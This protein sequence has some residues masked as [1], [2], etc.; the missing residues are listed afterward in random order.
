MGRDKAWLPWRGQPMVA[1]VVGVLRAVVDEVVVVAS[2][3]LELPP[4]E[5]RVVRDRE[6]A[7][8]PLAGLREGLAAMRAELA[9][10]TGTDA[11]FLTHAFV[12]ALLGCGRAAAPE[13]DG[14]VQTLSAVYPRSAAPLIDAMLAQGRSR[15]LQ[16]LERLDYRKLGE[17][18]LPDLDSVRGFNTPAEYLAAVRAAEPAAMAVLELHGRARLAVGCA[19]LEV[20]IGTLAEILAPIPA[21]IGILEADRVAAPFS[22]SID[23]RSAPYSAAIPIGPGERVCVRDAASRP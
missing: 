11:P 12:R 23:G 18:E 10:A 17:S 4:L 19:E 8:G 6:P 20:A 13:I 16:L 3:S 5:A 2:E 15:P 21:S 22:I 14:H 1:H 7:R 9:F